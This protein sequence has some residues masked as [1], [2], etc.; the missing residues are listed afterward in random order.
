MQ[1]VELSIH[2]IQTK[3]ELCLIKIILQSVQL[4]SNI[5]WSVCSHSMNTA[6][7]NS[8]PC[9][10]ADRIDPLVVSF[11]INYLLHAVTCNYVLLITNT[12][13]STY[14]VYVPGKM[15]CFWNHGTSLKTNHYDQTSDK[16][17]YRMFNYECVATHS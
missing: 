13:Q 10:A 12:A 4:L 2:G 16:L 15:S 9:I 8:A 6:P 17:S 3:I 11:P 1:H 5:K 14:P 7:V